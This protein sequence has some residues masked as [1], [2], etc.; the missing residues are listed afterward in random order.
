MCIRYFLLGLLL[1]WDRTSHADIQGSTE[2]HKQCEHPLTQFSPVDATSLHF[3]FS[4]SRAWHFR[5]YDER[6]SVACGAASNRNGK[7]LC[8]A[9]AVTRRPRLENGCVSL[10][11]TAH[12]FRAATAGV[13]IQM[14]ICRI[15]SD[16]SH[17]TWANAVRAHLLLYR[18]AV[19]A[20]IHTHEFMDFMLHAIVLVSG[21]IR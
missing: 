5:F 10:V 7:C 11:R 20:E 16:L 13:R 18:R 12:E 3:P 8:S 14:N 2:R 6:A 15:T 21:C 17:S 19:C 9:D 1:V 4:E